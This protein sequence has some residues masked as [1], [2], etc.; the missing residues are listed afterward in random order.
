[1]NKSEASRHGTIM[2][3]PESLQAVWRGFERWPDLPAIVAFGGTQVRTWSFGEMSRASIEIASALLRRGIARGDGV[4]LVAPNSP[5]WIMAFW[6]VVAAGAVVVPLDAQNDDRELSRMLE[7]GACRIAFTTATTARRLRLLAPHCQIVIVDD[8]AAGLEQEEAVGERWDDFQAGAGAELPTVSPDDIAVIVFTSGTTGNPKA[9]PLTHA[10]LMTNVLALEAAHLVGTGDRALLP[11]P[12]YHVYPLTIGMITPLALGCALVLPAGISGPELMAAIR[13]GSASVLLGVPRLYTA[14]VE[15]VR[16]GMA[17][18]PA[19]AAKLFRKLLAISL[20]AVRHRMRWPGRLLL[21]PLRRQIGSRLRLLVSGG[22]A[23]PLE[24]EETLDALGWEMLTGYGLVETS[25]MLTFTPRGAGVLGSAGRPVPGTAVRIVNAGE[26]GVGDIEVRGPSVFVGYRGD[27]AKTSEAFTAGGWFHTGDLGS[28]DAEGYLHITARKAETIVLA[29]GKKLFPEEFEA[30]YAGV[31]MV[32]EIA[33]LGHEGA[34]AAL[35]VPDLAA[36]RE[37]GAMRLG[38]ALREGLAEKS[39]TLPSYA[40]LS[41]FAVTHSALPRT[42]LGKLRR[43]LLPPLYATAQR[44]EPEAAPSPLSAEDGAL[45]EKAPT[46]AVLRWLRERFPARSLQLDTILQLDLG[47]DSLGWVDLTLALE[48]DFGIVLREKEIAQ[49]VTIRDL[50]RE[51]SAA[52]PT[53]AATADEGLWL[54]PLG[55]GLLLLSAMLEPLVRLVMRSAFRVKAAG[56]DNLPP[57]GPILICPNHVSYLDPFALGIALPRTRLR[58]TYWSGWSGIAFSTRFRRLFSR[59]ARIIPVDP[60]R[61]PGSGLVMGRMALERGWNL[62]WFPEGGR[63]ADG[64]LQRF[65]P[66]IGALVETRPVPIVPVHIAG[67]FAAWPIARRFPR[68]GPITVRFG[69]PIFPDHVATGSQG[70]RRD[71]AIA[72]AVHDAVSALAN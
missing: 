68:L 66:G 67:S 40:R 37:G 24:I 13:D 17:T 12:L 41:G 33:L 35:V 23:V 60:D 56:L 9:V 42:Q 46:A 61:A 34:L 71:E 62:V 18:L 10:N 25:S 59:I 26:N 27:P 39:R 38:D 48:R 2:R 8:L 11:L 43:H 19:P 15:N 55:P 36:A 58:H 51:A 53:E 30:V 3:H 6:G 50:L 5:R 14:L 32:R 63:S 20:W 70:R 16:R 65:L 45:L 52:R 49:I 72:A 22:A 47:V 54:E 69:P 31:P 44:H 4:A 21:F 7:L 57:V 64:T 1:M 28:I 29:D